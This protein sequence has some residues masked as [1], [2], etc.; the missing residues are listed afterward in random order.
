M[1]YYSTCVSGELSPAHSIW[2]SWFICQV[3]TS[4]ITSHGLTCYYLK[5]FSSLTVFNTMVNDPSLVKKAKGGGD[6]ESF[7]KYTLT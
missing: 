4:H 7:K 2:S 3:F 5:H 6:R 1:S